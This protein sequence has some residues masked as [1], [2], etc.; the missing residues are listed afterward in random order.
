MKIALVHDHLAQDGGAERVLR[1]LADM[2]PSAPIYTLLYDQQKTLNAYPGRRIEASIIQKMPGGVKHYQWYLMFMPLAVEFFDLREYD[3]VISD[4]SSFA[5]GVITS[6]TTTHIC[7]CH[8]PTRY[9]WSDAHQYINELKYNRWIKKIISLML[10]RLRLWDRAA[11]DR[12]DYF[13]ANSKIVQKRIT[14]YY[15]RDSVVIYPP[16]EVDNFSIAPSDP[17]ERPDKYFLIGCR[18]APYK[19]VDIVVEAF[20]ELGGEYRLKVFGDGVDLKRLQKIAGGASNIEFLGRVSDDDKAELYRHCLAF[21]NPQEEDFGIT[22]V[23]AMASGRPVIAYQKGGALETVEENVSGIFFSQQT[24]EGIISAVQDFMS[25]I[26]IFNPER[27]RERA[28]RFSVD[29]FKRGI[30]EFIKDKVN[31]ENRS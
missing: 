1:V 28:L 26:N 13:I 3:L 27:I 6:P 31:Y 4:T 10:T 23:E 30:D 17:A 8:T 16:V 20:K 9:L 7:Y 21:I 29:N 5:K 2:F 19:R 24:K 18:L 14:K 25:K 12:V 22:A 11:A 15:S